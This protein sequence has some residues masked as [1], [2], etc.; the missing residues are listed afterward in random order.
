MRL[1]CSS[2]DLSYRANRFWSAAAT[3][4]SEIAGT[5]STPARS[6]AV[7]SAFRARR[8]S[9]SDSVPSR[10]RASSSTERPVSPSPRSRS[11]SARAQISA[12]SSGASGSRTK[13]RVRERSGPTTSKLGFSVVAPMRV[14]APRSTCGRRASC[15]ARLKRWIS[16]TKRTVPRPVAARRA[17]ASSRTRR[18]RGIPSVTAEKGMN[19]ASIRLAS[20]PARVVLPVPGGPQKMRLGTRPLSMSWRRGRLSPTSFGCPTN[21]ASVRGRMRA[22]SGES[23]RPASRDRAAPG[24]PASAGAACGSASRGSASGN[25][26]GSSVIG[27]RHRR[28]AA[29]SRRRARQAGAMP[30]RASRSR[31]AGGPLR[32]AT[33]AR[34]GRGPR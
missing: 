34:C 22:A 10:A 12:T 23:A 11:R 7:S 25:R 9:P 29:R 17:F 31:S 6:A 30:R 32:G 4:S 15:C 2:P 20:S 19:A 14:M 1:K 24:P 13:T 5:P 21:S 26:L 27:V 16:S 33:L 8:A 18:T 3:W 28:R